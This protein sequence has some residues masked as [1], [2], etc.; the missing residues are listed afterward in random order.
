MFPFLKS[1]GL[2]YF[3]LFIPSFLCLIFIAVHLGSQ[4]GLLVSLALTGVDFQVHKLHGQ[5]RNIMDIGC[6]HLRLF[7]KLGLPLVCR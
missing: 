5:I 3:F 6:Y 1:D 7:L 4:I 2:F